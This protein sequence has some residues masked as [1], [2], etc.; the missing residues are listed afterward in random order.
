MKKKRL[1]CL[2]LCIS[3]ICAG[4]NKNIADPDQKAPLDDSSEPIMLQTEQYQ[5]DEGQVMLPYP[6]C[7]YVVL[8]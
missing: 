5:N 4:C 7:K 2:A 1:F 3:A 6:Y 8:P